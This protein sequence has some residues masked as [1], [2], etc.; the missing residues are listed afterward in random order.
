MAGAIWL[1]CIII[2]QRIGSANG[3]AC[4]GECGWLFFFVFFFLVVELTRMQKAQQA[5]KDAFNGSKSF[6]AGHKVATGATVAAIVGLGLAYKYRKNIFGKVA[7]LKTAKVKTS[8]P[9]QSRGHRQ[10]NRA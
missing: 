5:V 1:F 3:G 8:N 7:K 6:V 9:A 10:L 2:G 4:F